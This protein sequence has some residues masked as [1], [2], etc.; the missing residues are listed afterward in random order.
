MTD[1]TDIINCPAC[2]KEMQKIYLFDKGINIDICTFGC[3]GIYFD[4]QELQQFNQEHDTDEIDRIYKGLTFT[5][6]DQSQKRIC[7]CGTPMAKH[8]A[9][10]GVQI[11]NCYNCGG[12]FLDYGELDMI[13]NGLSRR[14]N[15]S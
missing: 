9:P 2:G 7:P 11:D 14:R 6:A 4:N 12:V 1:T 13:L 3:G 5:P 8:Y 15:F 10:G